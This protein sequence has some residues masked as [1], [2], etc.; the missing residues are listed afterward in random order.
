MIVPGGGYRMVAVGESEIVAKKF[1][2]K[3]Y[4]AFVLTYTTAMFEPVRLY[5]QPLNDLARAVAYLRKHAEKFLIDKN[6]VILCGFSAGGH[7]CGSLAA[8]YDDERIRQDGT[9]SGISIRP[10]GVILSYPVITSGEYA[11]KDSFQVLLGEKPE[12]GESEYMSLEKQVKEGMPPVF[13]WHTETDET[14]PVENTLLF[15]EA[16]RRKGVSCEMHI[17]REGIHGC[18]TADEKWASG[19]YGGDYVMDQWFAFMQYYID[20]ELEMPPPFQGVKLPRGT[21]YREFY[22]NS[23]KEFLK[24]TPNRAAAMWTELAGIWLDELFGERGVKNGENR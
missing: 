22:R 15:A 2:E 21:D 9:Y 10:D 18:S 1:Y 11:H 3:G 24:G 8:H 7:L 23:P 12:K 6:R 5:L 19:E 17:F 14:V 13:I 4:N 20:R 16:C